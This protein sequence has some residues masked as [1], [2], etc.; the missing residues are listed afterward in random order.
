MRLAA[1]KHPFLLAK[2]QPVPTAGARVA[3][4]ADSWSRQANKKRRS[5]RSLRWRAAVASSDAE[6]GGGGREDD[7]EAG[8]GANGTPARRRARL[9]ASRRESVRLPDGV[10]GDGIGAFLR[11][12][13]G[14]ESLLNTGALQSFAPGGSGPGTFTCTL[15]RI[16]LLGFELAPVLDLRVVPTGTDCT[17]EMLSCRVHTCASS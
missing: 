9:L 6:T 8:Q 16:R 4:A 13:A 17:I 2:H 10:S 3:A 14:V 5:S 1:G 11:D 7:D 15:R 12:P